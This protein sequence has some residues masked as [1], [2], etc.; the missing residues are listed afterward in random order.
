VESYAIEAIRTD[1]G[2]RPNPGSIEPQDPGLYL[3]GIL[4]EA[5]ESR[6]SLGL[7]V[8]IRLESKAVSG[9]ALVHAE[10]L[11]HLAAFKTR[12]HF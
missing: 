4:G 7:G 12:R 11:L 9:F 5:F 6:P 10:Q 3:Q 8:D 2:A 1:A